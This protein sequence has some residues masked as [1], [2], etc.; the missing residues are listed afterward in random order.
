MT[1][2]PVLAAFDKIE[3]AIA[4][5]EGSAFLV[6]QIVTHGESFD[7]ASRALHHVNRLMLADTETLR[8]RAAARPSQHPRFPLL[9]LSADAIVLSAPPKAVPREITP[10][11]TISSP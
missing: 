6:D 10:H 1:R 8:T 2:N 3:D 9:P 11:P 4:D 5:M 7:N